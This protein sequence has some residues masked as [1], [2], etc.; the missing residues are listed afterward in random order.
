MCVYT[1]FPSPSTLKHK[2]SFSPLSLLALGVGANQS[3]P[4]FIHRAAVREAE[5]L[6]EEEEEEEVEQPKQEFLCHFL[7]PRGEKL[8][9]FLKK[10]C[11][12]AERQKKEEKELKP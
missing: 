3:P 10:T 6:G 8:H 2:Q 4:P 1:L 11:D 9:F 5:Q 7:Q 12:R